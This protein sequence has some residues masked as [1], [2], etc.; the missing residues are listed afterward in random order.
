MTLAGRAV[1][2]QPNQDL[3]NQV[4]SLHRHHV[5]A[6]DLTSNLDLL[7]HNL[8]SFLERVVSLFQPV[9]NVLGIFTPGT[10]RLIN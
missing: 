8:Y 5:N 10:Q 6:L 3:S 2:F 4:F 9:D 7:S 1:E